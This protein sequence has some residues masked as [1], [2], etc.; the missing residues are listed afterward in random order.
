MSVN[1]RSVVRRLSHWLLILNQSI[2][3]ACHILAVSHLVRHGLGHHLELHL[4][5]FFLLLKLLLKLFELA[6]GLPD[7]SIKEAVKQGQS[8]TD[9]PESKRPLW[10]SNEFY[11]GA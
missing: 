9:K 4:G 2:V 10:P 8:H 1:D 5:L 6:L 7:A 11:V 3:L